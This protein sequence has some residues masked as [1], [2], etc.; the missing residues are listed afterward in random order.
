MLVW[1]KENGKDWTFRY[2]RHPI[3]PGSVCR[4]N[5]T[6]GW[7]SH[8]WSV[9]MQPVSERESCLLVTWYKF[10]GV[11]YAKAITPCVGSPPWDLDCSAAS[12]LFS[13]GIC[14]PVYT[15][16]HMQLNDKLTVQRSTVCYLRRESVNF[17]IWNCLWILCINTWQKSWNCNLKYV[18]KIET[19]VMTSR[20]SLNHCL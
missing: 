6:V 20:C 3:F 15:S 8:H 11:V 12:E 1:S 13:P 4:D 5:P 18:R 9:L 19:K 17:C 10:G 7:E 14:R 2:N 16:C